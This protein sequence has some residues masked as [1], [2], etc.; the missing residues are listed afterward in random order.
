VI[1][2]TQRPLPDKAQHSQETHIHAPGGIRTQN[3]RKRAAADLGLRP[4]GHWDRRN[5]YHLNSWIMVVIIRT[6]YCDVREHCL[7]PA[8]RIC[9]IYVTLRL[10]A[11]TIV[12]FNGVNWLNVLVKTQCF[13]KVGIG[14]F[15]IIWSNLR[16]WGSVH[17]GL[18]GLVNIMY[19][20]NTEFLTFYRKSQNIDALDSEIVILMDPRQR[21]P[22]VVYFF[23]Q[24]VRTD[25]M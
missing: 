3:P 4:R 22:E 21:L 18:H 15:D 8:L 25:W 1:S 6:I 2:P 13:C 24:N 17:T 9:E 16:V 12:S 23:M 10:T 19:F 20:G 11:I 7:L 5:A 14:F